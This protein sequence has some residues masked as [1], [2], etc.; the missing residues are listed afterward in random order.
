[1]SI[2][3][4]E[5]VEKIIAEHHLGN[6]VERSL[7]FGD[8]FNWTP[9]SVDVM[10]DERGYHNYR[11]LGGTLRYLTTVARPDISHAVRGLSHYLAEPYQIHYE[12]A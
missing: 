8:K 1:M 3:S 10:L 9:S 11:Q 4:R 5:Y 12:G 2:S 6:L 7:P